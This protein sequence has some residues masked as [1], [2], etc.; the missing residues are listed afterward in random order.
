M[1]KIPSLTAVK[2]IRA[3]KKAGFAEDR[4]KGG[5]L[6]LINPKTKART[7]VPVHPGKTVRKSLVHAIVDDAKLTVDEFV[8]LL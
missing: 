7:I 6:I 4:Q 1:S 5:H 2:I 3:L 8:K